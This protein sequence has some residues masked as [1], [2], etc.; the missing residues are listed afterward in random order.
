MCMVNKD[1]RSTFFVDEFHCSSAYLIN[2][3]IYFVSV[4]ICSV[5][6]PEHTCMRAWRP[7]VNVRIFLCY[8]VAPVILCLDRTT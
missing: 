7:E 2:F 8:C 5:H 1:D 4:C 3:L 6:A